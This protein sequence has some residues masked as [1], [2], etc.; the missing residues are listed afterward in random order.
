LQNVFDRQLD[1][2]RAME[3]ADPH[4]CNDFLHGNAA[5]SFYD[6]V[7]DN[8]SLMSRLAQANLYAII[9]GQKIGDKREAPSDDDFR[10]LEEAL[11]ARGLET[12]EIESL[13]DGRPPDPPLPDASM[14]H[15][16]RLYLETLRELP[17]DLRLRIYALTIQLQAGI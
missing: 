16:G 17:E 11:R 5:P 10:T 14:C 1:V 8:R 15:A 13:L 3:A 6:F 9:D 12:P 2:V 4:I 7:R